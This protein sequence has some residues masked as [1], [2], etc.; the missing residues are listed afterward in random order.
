MGWALARGWVLAQDDTVLEITSLVH[1][2]ALTADSDWEGCKCE[3][4][5]GKM[6]AVA[7]VESS[8]YNTSKHAQSKSVDTSSIVY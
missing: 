5:G 3:V 7:Y 1:F 4:Y 2:V 6:I 8:S